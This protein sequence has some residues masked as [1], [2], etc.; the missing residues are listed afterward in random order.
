M[1]K[2]KSKKGWTDAAE[3]ILLDA[4]DGQKGERSEFI[5]NMNNALHDLKSRTESVMDTGKLGDV[6]E[7]IKNKLQSMWA[8]Y[9]LSDYKGTKHFCLHGREALNHDIL[10]ENLRH[11][12][13]KEQFDTRSA[14]TGSKSTAPEVMDS[15]RKPKTTLPD[16]ATEV[17][18][19]STEP[20]KSLHS[21]AL[22]RRRNKD[23][24]EW[25]GDEDEESETDAG[26]ARKKVMLKMGTAKR[27][28]SKTNTISK[29]TSSTGAASNGDYAAPAAVS[30]DAR[31]T[32]STSESLTSAPPGPA[33]ACGLE[34]DRKRSDQLDDE[35]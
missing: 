30:K 21:P 5:V 16:E 32:L 7:A 15:K 31:K 18:H 9:R 27:S 12:M 2:A 10:P 24:E 35:F 4:V 8:R 11:Q 25:H 3:E 1:P 17:M 13:P 23:E 29:R 6:S 33:I 28:T 19:G 20:N 34:K 22:K 14:K 26:P